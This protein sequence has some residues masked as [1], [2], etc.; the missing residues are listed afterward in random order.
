MVVYMDP[1]GTYRAE[2]NAL[3]DCVLWATA[4]VLSLIIATY[5]SELEEPVHAAP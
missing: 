4:I 1:L 2:D 5:S 3:S